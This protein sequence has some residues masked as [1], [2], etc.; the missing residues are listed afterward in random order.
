MDENINI[1]YQFNNLTPALE[2]D[3]KELVEFNITGKVDSYLKKI[4]KKEDAVI[5][6]EIT[7]TKNKKERYE[8]IFMFH[9]DHMDFRY[10]RDFRNPDDLVNH[11]FD[12]LKDFLSDKKNLRNRWVEKEII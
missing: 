9:L 12:R 3:I 2:D 11:A 4:L 8:W 6:I 10:E 1:K 5:N 7:I